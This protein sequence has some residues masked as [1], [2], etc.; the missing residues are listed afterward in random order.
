MGGGYRGEDA[1]PARRIGGD[2]SARPRK[3]RDH[4]TPCLHRTEVRIPQGA[5]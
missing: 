1:A 2:S 3:F 4:A 5:D